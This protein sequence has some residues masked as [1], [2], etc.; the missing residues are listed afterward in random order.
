MKALIWTEDVCMCVCVCVDDHGERR[1]NLHFICRRCIFIW[2]FVCV[3]F[4]W[5]ECSLFLAKCDIAWSHQAQSSIIIIIIII[6]IYIYIYM[7]ISHGNGNSE[8]HFRVQVGK[9]TNRSSTIRYGHIPLA[10]LE[11]RQSV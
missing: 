8:A 5:C 2:I 11:K 10:M 9:S 3:S 1:E 7:I 6:F 4:P